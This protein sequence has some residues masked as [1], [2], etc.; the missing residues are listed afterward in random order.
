MNSRSL[1]KRGIDFDQAK[2]AVLHGYELKFD[3]TNN[4][5]AARKVEKC[6][7][8]ILASEQN[9]SSQMQLDVN[10][11]PLFP[12][13]PATANLGM[14]PCTK[15]PENKIPFGGVLYQVASDQLK[16]IDAVELGLK[17]TQ[18]KAEFFNE[19][20]EKVTVDCYVYLDNVLTVPDFSIDDSPSHTGRHSMDRSI[21]GSK[22]IGCLP[23]ERY[24]DTLI[25]GAVEHNVNP[26]HIEFLKNVEKKPRVQKEHFKKIM[27]GVDE[28]NTLG[29]QKVAPKFLSILETIFPLPEKDPRGEYINNDENTKKRFSQPPLYLVVNDKLLVYTGPENVPVHQMVK[30]AY[31]KEPTRDRFLMSFA[32]T[33]YDPVYGTPES[34]D[35]MCSDQRDYLEHLF[36]E[37]MWGGV[38]NE[39]CG[40]RWKLSGNRMWKLVGY[41]A[42][43][44]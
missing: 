6:S 31:G 24:L 35:K 20:N 36:V 37:T 3:G 2:P 10:G 38:E 44:Y 19:N 29:I 1:S 41:V 32:H 43:L 7:S 34:F 13:P 27:H 40:D 11:N 18:A 16:K 8:E 14:S 12:F 4:T 9:D 21:S 28:A 5:A 33:M 17:R 22:E 39:T 15:K 23:D 42:D 26:K 25:E 30:H